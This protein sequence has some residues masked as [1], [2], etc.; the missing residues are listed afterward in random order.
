MVDEG[1]DGA[2]AVNGLLRNAPHPQQYQQF[3][4]AYNEIVNKANDAEKERAETKEKGKKA[5]NK[6]FQELV[7]AIGCHL[8]ERWKTYGGP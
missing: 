5:C 2:E 4:M 6:S 3:V 1:L 7:V 8:D